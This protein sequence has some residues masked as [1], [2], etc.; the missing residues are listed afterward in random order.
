MVNYISLLTY[1]NFLHTPAKIPLGMIRINFAS[2]VIPTKIKAKNIHTMATIKLA[3]V[4]AE[5]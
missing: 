1:Q 4:Y 2:S 3:K 5:L